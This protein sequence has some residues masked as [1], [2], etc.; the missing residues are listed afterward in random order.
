MCQHPF[1]RGPHVKSGE[2]GQKVLEKKTF[3]DFKVLYLY[4]AQGQG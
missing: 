3:E 1:D 2:N 4:I